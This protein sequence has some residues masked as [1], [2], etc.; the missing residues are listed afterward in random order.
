MFSLTKLSVTPGTKFSLDVKMLPGSMPLASPCN[1][2]SQALC[3]GFLSP[4]CPVRPPAPPEGPLAVSDVGRH[5]RL[6][7]RLPFNS[8]PM[9]SV[10]PV[11]T[12]CKVQGKIEVSLI[13]LNSFLS[14]H[15][16]NLNYVFEPTHVNLRC[17]LSR[18]QS[19]GVETV[20]EDA[21]Q[22]PGLSFR[23][24]RGRRAHKCSSYTFFLFVVGPSS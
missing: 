13:F 5:P 16:P 17:T 22:G 9:D 12:L 10:F 18:S 11:E 3:P 8:G 24:S 20:H 7:V 19:G 1:L 21:R 6:P 4:A 23:G 15:D 14:I 2:S